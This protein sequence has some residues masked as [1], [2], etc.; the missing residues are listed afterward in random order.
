VTF[1]RV[2]FATDFSKVSNRI[3]KSLPFSD[4]TLVH[5]INVN[6]V[7]GL[8]AGFNIDEW[9]S[10]EIDFAC[11]KLSSMV[12]QLN[13]RGVKA[14]F[15]CPIPVG[16][17]ATEI[18]NTAK[19]FGVSAIVI[20]AR[21]RSIDKDILLGS[22]AEGV[23]RRSDIPVIVV[24]DKLRFDRVLF[25]HD[26]SKGAWSILNYIDSKIVVIH[27]TNG[28]EALAKSKLSNLN[29]KVEKVVIKRGEPSKEILKCEKDE[30]VDAI[31]LCGYGV[32]SDAVL[33]HSRISVI[34][35]PNSA[36]I[37]GSI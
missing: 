17:P 12:E 3:F 16:D 33:R 32:T 37:P 25:A 2:L 7:V 35:F 28:S 30:D 14:R 11:R 15:V 36:L 20:G 23:I 1:K 9:L 27:V 24:R 8:R 19:R 18:V 34:Y 13:D 26:L 31:V 29:G 10:Y 4:V 6:S 5:V 22:V 21:G